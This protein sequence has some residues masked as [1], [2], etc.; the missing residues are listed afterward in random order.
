MEERAREE[1]G[2]D[3][4]ALGAPGQRFVAN[5]IPPGTTPLC[6]HFDDLCVEDYPVGCIGLERIA[7]L[8]QTSDIERAQAICPG[9]IDTAAT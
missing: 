9:N 5:F 3:L 6:Q 1:S 8:K 4:R 2:Q 7:A